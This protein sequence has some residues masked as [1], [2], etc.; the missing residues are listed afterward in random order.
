MWMTINANK[1]YC[2]LLIQVK[3][4]QTYRVHDTTARARFMVQTVPIEEPLPTLHMSMYSVTADELQSLYGFII[5]KSVHLKWPAESNQNQQ[6]LTFRKITT[7]I[8]EMKS[9]LQ[10]EHRT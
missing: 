2:R 5:A 4:S 10:N 8:E 7:A 6:S 3:F 9:S 1:V